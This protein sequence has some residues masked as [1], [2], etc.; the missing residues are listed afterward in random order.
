MEFEITHSLHAWEKSSLSSH[1]FRF[2]M[3]KWKCRPCNAMIKWNMSPRNVGPSQCAMDVKR[4]TF[5]EPL[6]Q[7][8]VF[9][10]IGWL[11]GEGLGVTNELTRCPFPVSS[12]MLQVCWLWNLCLILTFV[13][14]KKCH[15][16]RIGYVYKKM[17]WRFL[18]FA[19]WPK[20]HHVFH[21][22]SWILGTYVS[23]LREN[24]VP[25]T[26]DLLS[27]SLMLWG[28][29]SVGPIYE[30]HSLTCS[31]STRCRGSGDTQ[32][33]TCLPP[34][35]EEAV[36]NTPV[37][38]GGWCSHAGTHHCC[39]WPVSCFMEGGCPSW[40]LRALDVQPWNLG[41]RIL[42]LRPGPGADTDCNLCPPWWPHFS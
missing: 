27:T 29:P 22:Q 42:C 39:S 24:K 1:S 14:K 31:L 16:I 4:D 33:V 2:L 28:I 12:P 30:L 11:E 32:G 37:T 3:Y 41:L 20:V 13:W 25:R 40:A 21:Y 17:S 6:L 23:L 9:K 5:F 15:F 7:N 18:L 36:M 35:E 26:G 10:A 19:L 38:Q 8:C 34:G